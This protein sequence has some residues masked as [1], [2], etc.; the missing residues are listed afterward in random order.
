MSEMK[1]ILE[2]WDR[3]LIFENDN[4]ENIK[5]NPQDVKTLG[6]ELVKA[7]K[8]KLKG[9]L[10]IV[11]N[12]PEIMDLVKSF[13]QM[14]ALIDQDLQENIL[15]Q[16]GAT[17]Y[18]KAQ[19]FFDSDLGQKVKTYGAPAAA[20]AYMA[21]QLTQGGDVDPEIMKDALEILAKGK[22]LKA[23]DV[24]AMASGLETGMTEQEN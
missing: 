24:V 13:E 8:D 5:N 11:S 7:N 18:V 1:M 4:L 17:A 23:A 9:F 21:F 3:Y 16:L 22:N 6:D 19:K 14:S 10:D 15:D 2:R 12:D 20:I